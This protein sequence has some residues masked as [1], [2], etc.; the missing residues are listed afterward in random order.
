MQ[1]E[2]IPEWLLQAIER[3]D[4]KLLLALAWSQEL[5][6]DRIDRT[7][8]TQLYMSKIGKEKN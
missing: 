1:T 6:L 2:R 4:P 3:H 8:G 7:L 5:K